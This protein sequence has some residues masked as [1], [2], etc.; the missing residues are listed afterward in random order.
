MP[1]G[2]NLKESQLSQNL[3]QFS[4]REIVLSLGRSNTST[5]TSSFL[6]GYR[7]KSSEGVRFRKWTTTVL[8][9]YLI[10]GAAIN[11]RRLHEIDKIVIGRSAAVGDKNLA[12]FGTDLTGSRLIADDA[13]LTMGT[14]PH[15]V[16]MS[17]RQLLMTVTGR[18]QLN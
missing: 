4:S 7:V 1:F 17:A 10:E 5:W 14:G 16:R 15:E 18:Q 12:Y 3:R 9:E 8:R 13:D 2:K 6:V 11:E